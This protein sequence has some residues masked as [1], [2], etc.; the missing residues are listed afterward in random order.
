VACRPCRQKALAVRRTTTPYDSGSTHPSAR[1]RGAKPLG[2]PSSRVMT[3][4]ASALRMVSSK[5][6]NPI[7]KRGRNRQ[8]VIVNHPPTF[9]TGLDER[10]PIRSDLNETS[11][12][13]LLECWK[14][15]TPRICVTSNSGNAYN[16]PSVRNSSG[17]SRQRS[18][19]AFRTIEL[20]ADSRGAQ[21]KEG[22]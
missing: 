13:R 3:S 9:T 11:R 12:C 16:P 2:S 5:R 18:L 19:F 22:L 4:G 8:S 21:A 7:Q 6:G 1:S 17:E 15:S 20:G 14:P 10:A